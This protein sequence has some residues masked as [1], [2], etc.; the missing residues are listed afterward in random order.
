MV[1]REKIVLVGRPPGNLASF[2]LPSGE[3]YVTPQGGKG[4]GGKGTS[5]LRI[6]GE[7]VKGFIDYS[8]PS[9]KGENWVVSTRLFRKRKSKGGLSGGTTKFPAGGQSRSIEKRLKGN[10]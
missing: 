3:R 10:P 1:T 8:R 9:E 4:K 5:G 2:G 6:S 7:G